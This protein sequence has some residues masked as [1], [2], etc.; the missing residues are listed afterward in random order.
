[1]MCSLSKKHIKRNGFHINPSKP[2]NIV[3][4]H[5]LL[6]KTLH[7]KGHNNELTPDEVHFGKQE[8]VL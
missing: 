3:T 4:I 1:M 8:T 5:N 2:K 6:I 7:N